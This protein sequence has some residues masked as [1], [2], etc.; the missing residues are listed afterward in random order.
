MYKLNLKDL[1]P[2]FELSEK[3]WNEREINS[4]NNTLPF[5]EFIKE[6][7][8]MMWQVVNIY[9]RNLKP[10]E[11]Y[12]ELYYED[13][14]LA[15]QSENLYLLEVLIMARFIISNLEFEKTDLP[16]L[17]FVTGYLKKTVNK[18][19]TWFAKYLFEQ[20]LDTADNGYEG[21][22]DIIQSLSELNKEPSWYTDFRD[23]I[24]K[25]VYRA[26]VNNEVLSATMRLRGY[27]PEDIKTD[28]D[29]YVKDK[30]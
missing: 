2:Y 29:E 25:L 5:R 4:I 1:L 13:V 10:H 7:D 28:I 21:Y 30:Y 26:P 15:I 8:R 18:S 24:I 16:I 27:L 12:P 14:N 3:F 11:N 23:Q 17:N 9:M 6:K 20:I 19:H 22:V